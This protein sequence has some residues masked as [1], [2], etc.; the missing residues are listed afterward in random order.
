[1]AKGLIL[2]LGLP[3]GKPAAKVDED[4]VDENEDGDEGNEPS[5]ERIE[6]AQALIDAVKAGD[7]KGVDT[8]LQAHWMLCEETEHEE[9]PPE[10]GRY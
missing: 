5:G 8:A 2:A 1:M 6:A 3:K 4:Q 10:S 9:G 7:A